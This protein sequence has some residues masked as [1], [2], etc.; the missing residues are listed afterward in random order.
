MVNY[1]CKSYGHQLF[2]LFDI[3]GTAVTFKPSLS[4]MSTDKTSYGYDQPGDPRAYSGLSQEAPPP[5]PSEQPSAYSA[6]PVMNQ[7]VTQPPVTVVS[8]PAKVETVRQE[9]REWSTGLCDCCQDMG[10]CEYLH[11]LGTRVI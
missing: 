8:G 2:S 5:Y 10:T 7:P 9:E 4:I 6:P 1:K 11:F 3:L